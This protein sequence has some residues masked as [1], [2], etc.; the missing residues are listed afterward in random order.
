M[1]VLWDWC[2]IVILPLW[3]P[4]QWD[5]CEIAMGSLAM[6]LLWDPLLY[7]CY[8]IPCGGFA[9]GLLW[10]PLRL[11]REALAGRR[12]PVVVRQASGRESSVDY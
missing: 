3:D 10:G 9:M 8:G 4:L 11:I 6:G 5:C 2:G 12:A 7:D 1:G